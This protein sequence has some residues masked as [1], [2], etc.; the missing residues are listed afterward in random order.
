MNPCPSDPH[1]PEPVPGDDHPP[2]RC[3]VPSV[4]HLATGALLR[5][6][7]IQAN[8]SYQ[9]VHKC[10]GI[11]DRQL[12]GIELARR[13]L[14]EDVARTLLDFYGAGQEVQAVAALLSGGHVHQAR[15]QAFQRGSWMTALMAASQGA[16]MLSTGPLRLAIGLATPAPPPPGRAQYRCRTTLLLHEPALNRIPVQQ[17]ARLI[18]LIERRTLTVRLVP[19]GLS[20]PEGLLTEWSLTAG[21]SGTSAAACQ[22]RRLY[23]THIPEQAPLARN[24][25]PAHPDRQMIQLAARH[26]R[27]PQDSTYQLRQAAHRSRVRA[28]LVDPAVARRA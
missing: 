10:T 17:L 13:P 23:V 20:V 6:C 4:P 26:A 1:D 2:K 11:S 9:R 14:E 27:S 21:T 7:R 16:V 12:H 15:D 18:A 5:Y 3:A 19:G 22:R 25:E 8:L 24:G 28:A